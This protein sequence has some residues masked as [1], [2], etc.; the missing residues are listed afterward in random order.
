MGEES[1]EA[2]LKEMMVEKL[3]LTIDPSEIGDEDNL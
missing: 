1:I 2:Q 3:A